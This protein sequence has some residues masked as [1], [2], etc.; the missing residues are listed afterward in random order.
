MSALTRLALLP[1]ALI[2][3]TMAMPALAHGPERILFI[4]NSFTQGAN[5]AVLRYRPDSVEDLN[6]EKPDDRVGGIPALFAKFAEQA[7][8]EWSVAHELRGGTTLDFH[9]NEKREAIDQG[10]DV[11]VMQ[12]FS[13]LNPERPLDATD[14]RRDAP[15][16][17]EMFTA[18]KPDVRV[19]LMSTWSRADQTY[20]PNGHWYGQP[21]ETM[22]LDLRRELDAVDR[23]SDD[24][25]AVIPVGEAWNAAIAAG[26]AD[27]NPYDG[28][29]YGTIDLWSYDHYH[30]SAEGSYL[31]ALTVFAQITGYDVRKFGGTERA[32]HELGIEGKVAEQLQAI[33]ARQVGIAAS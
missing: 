8:M 25:D 32:A 33:A 14:T 17:A 5:S 9:L 13:T 20:K 18:A 19:Y 31:E 4:G 28:R 26:I 1:A 16:L 23:A 2:A 21:I 24:I 15:A 29:D 3:S 7:G 6:A 27:P 12:Q 30:A 11:V 10:W 22:A